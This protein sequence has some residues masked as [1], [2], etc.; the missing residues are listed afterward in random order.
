MERVEDVDKGVDVVGKPI[1]GATAITAANEEVQVEKMVNEKATWNSFSGS[2]RKLEND[3]ISIPS[4]RGVRYFGPSKMSFFNLINHSLS[5]ISV[6]KKTFLIRASFFV[7]IYILLIKS[8]A[9]LITALP[10]IV[11][12]VAV[13]MISNLALRENL[14]EFD[15]ALSTLTNI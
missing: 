5:I 11:L 15:V 4:I 13:Y 1:L 7:V 12:F 9:S 2:L 8:N 3:L 6:F 10:L 14:K